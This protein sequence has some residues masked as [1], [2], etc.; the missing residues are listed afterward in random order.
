MRILSFPITFLSLTLP[1][2]SGKKELEALTR[3]LDRVPRSRA[4]RG[5]FWP[6]N[7]ATRPLPS[8]AP[9]D[10][11]GRLSLPISSLLSSL[12]ADLADGAR[13]DRVAAFADGEPQSLLHGNRGD[14]LNHQ[15][16]VVARHHHL[17]AR[18]QFGHSRHVRGSQVE[19]R[20]ISLEER[21]MPPPFFL[22][23]HVHLGLELGVRRDRA[24]LLQHHAALHL[25]LADA[26]QQQSSVVARHAFVQLLLEHLNP[27]H[28]RLAGLA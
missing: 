22:G 3:R 8:L 1:G 14:Q 4:K 10:S 7:F 17:G 21:R 26:T 18:R 13:A 28:H 15:L 23:Q 11:R 6:P 2:S 12:L 19:L 20:T 27:G 9:P 5:I 16:Y 24:R 25:V